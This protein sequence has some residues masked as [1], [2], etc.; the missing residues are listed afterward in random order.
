V[1]RGTFLD[2]LSRGGF[3]EYTEFP[4]TG[5]LYGTPTF[6]APEGKD[7]NGKDPNG[8]DLVLEIELD[9]ARQ[10]KERHPDAKLI[11][12]VAPSREAR[13]ARLRARGDSEEHIERRLTVGE[14]EERIGRK[15]AD[16]VV[17][18][19]D[20]E[21]AAREVAGILEQFRSSSA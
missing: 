16:A 2:R 5:H 18:N 6:E 10:V 7:P 15:L 1:D 14:E 8:K 21:R 17:V 3:V 4:G 13:E 11:M 20:V 12:I 19:D 9:G